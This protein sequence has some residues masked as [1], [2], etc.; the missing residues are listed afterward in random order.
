[1]QNMAKVSGKP[2]KM[3]EHIS[4]ISLASSNDWGHAGAVQPK[5][6]WVH[7]QTGLDHR[8]ELGDLDHERPAHV[9]EG[10]SSQGQGWTGEQKGL[11]SSLMGLVCVPTLW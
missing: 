11:N 4:T 3:M 2:K 8:G 7:S 6:N 9:Y 10:V 1:M 5:L